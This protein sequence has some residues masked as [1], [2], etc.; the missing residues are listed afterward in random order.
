MKGEAFL[1]D[2][3]VSFLGKVTPEK[4]RMIQ[5]AVVYFESTGIFDV[6]TAAGVVLEDL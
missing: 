6:L 5:V 3:Y 2:I 1:G 4:V